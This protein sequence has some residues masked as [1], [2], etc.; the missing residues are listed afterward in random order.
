MW[1]TKI[2]KYPDLVL[3]NEEAKKPKPDPAI[4]QMA[5]ACYHIRPEEALAVEDNEK[6]VR[7]AT[8][9]GVAVLRV[10]GPQEVTYEN[11]SARC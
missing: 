11:V 4:Y 10:E 9:A 8:A 1:R 7:S 5:L 6:G 2:E 3:S